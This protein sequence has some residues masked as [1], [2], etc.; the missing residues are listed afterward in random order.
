SCVLSAC[1]SAAGHAATAAP[2]LPDF[3][4]KAEAMPQIYA[5]N[6]ARLSAAL[7]QIAALPADRITFTDSALAL[8]TAF[9]DFS[10]ALTPLTFLAQVSPD[11]TIREQAH[12]IEKESNRFLID[13]RLREDVYRAIQ[14]H[15]AKGEVRTGEDQKL[16]ADILQN[17]RRNGLGLPADKREK[18][19]ALMQ[20]ISD[21]ELDCENNI[22]EDRTALTIP[23]DA[24]TGAPADFRSDLKAATDGKVSIPLDYPRYSALMENAKQPEIRRQAEFLFNNKAA[25]KN[26]PLI[27]ELL[28]K[29]HDLAALLGYP[30]YAHYSLDYRRTAKTPKRAR[31]FL[32]RLRRLLA[33]QARQ[34]LKALFDLKRQEEPTAQ[35]IENWDLTGLIG[36]QIGYYQKKYM[37]SKYGVDPEQVREYFPVDRVVRET[38]LLNQELLGLKFLELAQASWH[39]ETRLFEVQDAASGRLIAHFYLDLYPREGK[40]NH[41]AAFDLIRGRARPD[42]SYRLPV[43]AMVGNFTRSAAD[44]PALMSHEE[45]TTFFH[46]F[47]HIMHQTLTTA[48]YQSFSGSN[49]ALDFVEAPS[50]MSENFAWNPKVLDRL[51]GHYKDQTRKLPPALLAKMLAAKNALSALQNLRLVALSTL[52]LDLH[53]A[54]VPKDTTASMRA[55][56]AS[57]GYLKPTPATH[58]E[59]RFGHILQGYAAGYYGYLWAQMFAQDIFSRFEKE[60]VMNPAVGM[61]YRKKI[62]ERGS[63]VDEELSLRE[64]LGREPDESAFLNSLGIKS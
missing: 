17:F 21:L 49:V 22:K 12:A 13:L 24:L 48:K 35:R 63:S 33:P 52:D 40:Y 60:G 50:Q 42:G 53:D 16:L 29:R 30:S 34:E 58:F 37:Q 9:A 23:L 1:L 15:A 19:K 59:A 51:S 25:A 56:F 44:Q 43:A 54:V 41:M 36:Q 6:K 5:E 39:P 27:K 31:D 4:I 2:L 38:L 62:L 14:A 55:S 61:D 18:L 10:D 57:A 8:E 7:D 26:L 45:V 28:Q 32:G 11:R 20:R 46:E 47:G 3:S 64:F